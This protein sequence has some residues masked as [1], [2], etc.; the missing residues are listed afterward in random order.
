MRG[1]AVPPRIGHTPKMVDIVVGDVNSI[2]S[3]L[4][5]SCAVVG[6]GSVTA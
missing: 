4:G 3:R 6:Q 1:V 5:R 2:G